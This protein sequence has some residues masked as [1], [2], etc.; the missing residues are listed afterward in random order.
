[1]RIASCFGLVSVMAAPRAGLA[2]PLQ[3]KLEYERLAAVVL[4]IGLIGFALDA[5]LQ[6]L[7]QRLSWLRQ[8]HL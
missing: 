1:M 6:R 4:I 5:T 2:C 7:I 8:D 3:G